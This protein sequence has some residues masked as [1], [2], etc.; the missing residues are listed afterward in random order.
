MTRTCSKTKKQYGRCKQPSLPSPEK[1]C[2]AHTD[3]KER[4]V[5]NPDAYYE[6]KMFA[7]VLQPA[8]SL[9]TKSEL[10]ATLNGR[11][12]GDGRRVDQYVI[13]DPCG[14]GPD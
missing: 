8:A 2:R 1:W 9:F 6:A 10:H 4:G 14:Y 3:W 5:K 12:R 11:D 13:G 7:G